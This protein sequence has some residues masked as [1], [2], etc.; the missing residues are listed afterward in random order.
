MSDAPPAAPAPDAD[1]PKQSGMQR[2]AVKD[3]LKGMLSFF[4]VIRL[5]VGQKEF[6]AMERNFCLAPVLGWL[7]GGVAAAVCLLLT[8]AN[9]SGVITAAAALATVFLFSK[10]L[11]FDGLTDFGDGMIVSSGKR[12]DHVRA[13]KD[14]LIGAG[15]FGVALTVTLLS[16]ACYSWLAAPCLTLAFVVWPAEILT[17]NA[18]VAAAAYG[19]PG[20]GMASRQVRWTTGKSLAV[21]TAV[22]ALL[23]LL[24]AGI[25]TLLAPWFPTGAVAPGW[26]L[27]LLLMLVGLVGSVVVG[28]LMARTANRTFGFVNG[29]ILGATNEISR[30]VLL[31]VTAILVGVI[32]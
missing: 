20:N 23:L 15:G 11:H 3:A 19:R 7:I 13:L 16:F 10:F 32:Q 24:T 27:M 26:G 29:D 21:S 12:E 25:I 31:L 2:N 9:L 1:Q 22:S 18:M 14:T 4:T 6:D 5:N 30:A 28:A 17:K 8:W